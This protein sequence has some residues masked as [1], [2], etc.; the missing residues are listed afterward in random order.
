MVGKRRLGVALA[1]ASDVRDAKKKANL[2]AANVDI[3]I[4]P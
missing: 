3:E 2:V 4:K 1:A